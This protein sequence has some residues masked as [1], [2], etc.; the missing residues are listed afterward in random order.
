M[1]TLISSLEDLQKAE[2][3][4]KDFPLIACDLE[5]SSLD[6]KTAKIEG[7]GFGT[8]TNLFFIPFPNNISDEDVKQFIDNLFESKCVIFHNAKYDMELLLQNNFSV[9]KVFQ[10]TMIMSWLIDEN[11]AHGLKPLAKELFGREGKEWKDLKREIDLFT[12]LD[13]IM[14]ELAEYCC[15]DVRNTFDL[16]EHFSKLLEKEGVLVDYERVELPLIPVL[17]GMEMNG[18][19]LYSLLTAH[20]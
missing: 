11:G 13:D 18:I 14:L 8:N 10:D 2:D 20:A 5:A 12:N 7:I 16:Y 3:I 4:L 19:C 17:I 6:I 9:P 1:F 15:E